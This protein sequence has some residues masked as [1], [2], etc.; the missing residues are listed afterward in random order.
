MQLLRAKRCVYGFAWGGEGLCVHNCR[1]LLAGV[2]SVPALMPA[3]AQLC[4]SAIHTLR[5]QLPISS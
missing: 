2:G 3:T 4:N 1:L 5:I